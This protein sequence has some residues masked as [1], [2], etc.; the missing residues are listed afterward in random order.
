MFKL[1][2]HALTHVERLKLITIK[3]S[4][5]GSLFNIKSSNKL[6]H[7]NKTLHSFDLYLLCVLCKH[8]WLSTPCRRRHKFR[9][10][11]AS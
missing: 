5:C 6:P 7:I 8:S 9:E 10:K 2:V 11:V 4:N 1:R 3:P